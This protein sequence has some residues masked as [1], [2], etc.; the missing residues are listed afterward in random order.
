MEPAARP[1]AAAYRELN[2]PGG[3][4]LARCRGTP[5][6]D[7]RSTQTTGRHA[8]H[9]GSRHAPPDAFRGFVL[10]TAALIAEFVVAASIVFVWIVRFD[11]IVGRFKPA[12]YSP[13]ARN[14]V[15]IA[16]RS[17]A[18]VIGVWSPVLVIP[19]AL[20]I[21]ARMGRAQWAHVRV[22]NP[23]AKP[24]RSDRRTVSAAA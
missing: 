2:V 1:C 24:V 4:A 6:L 20:G 17:L 5:R 13:L 12:S 23:A 22:S 15:G 14:A 8:P 7:E 19:A 16:K 11:S 3:S 10:H 9:S 21:A 18:S